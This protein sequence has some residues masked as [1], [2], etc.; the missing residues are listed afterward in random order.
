M[1]EYPFLIITVIY[2]IIFIVLSAVKSKTVPLPKI[3][4]HSREVHFFVAWAFSLVLVLAYFTSLTVVR[5]FIR[6]KM[7][8][9]QRVYF[10]LKNMCASKQL[11]IDRYWF[12]MVFNLITLVGIGIISWWLTKSWTACVLIIFVDLYILCIM[13]FYTYLIANDFDILQNIENVNIRV[14][15]HNFRQD[16]LKKEIE[17]VKQ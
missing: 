13:N 5:L 6:R 15:Q 17:N 8:A 7:G 1:P 4:I 12:F 3:T 2:I 11:R 16:N 10:E 14:N 9:S